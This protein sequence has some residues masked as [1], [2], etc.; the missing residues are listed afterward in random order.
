MVEPV[1]AQIDEGRLRAVI[2]TLTLLEVLVI[3]CRVGDQALAARYEQVLG[4]S[5]GLALVPI[6]QALLRAT[7]LLRARTRIRTPDAIQIAAALGAGC[8]KFVTND[9][10]LPAIP[11]LE[12]VQLRDHL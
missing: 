8:R 11:G 1:F 4:N 10:E 12:V 2:S 3:P 9:R 7:A 6:D 5:R